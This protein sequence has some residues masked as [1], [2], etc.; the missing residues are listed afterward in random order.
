MFSSTSSP[1][2]SKT[3]ARGLQFKPHAS[4]KKYLAQL[5][6]YVTLSW[7]QTS[8]DITRKDEAK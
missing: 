3:E 5:T 6:F 7:H 2:Q 8:N 4:C 1:V